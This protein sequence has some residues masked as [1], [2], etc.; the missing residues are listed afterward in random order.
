MSRYKVGIVSGYFDSIHAGHLDYITEA[1]KQCDYLVAIVNSD[2]QM[3]LKGCRK[4][5]GETERLRTVQSIKG[6]SLA[7]LSMDKDESVANTL[8]N[9]AALA[10]TMGHRFAFLPQI[11][12][13]FFNGGDR[14]LGTAN[15]KE[16]DICRLFNI[17]VV[18]LGGDKVDSSTR[19][20][21]IVFQ[22]SS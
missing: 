13:V 12:L 5:F 6:V 17:E 21:E 14:T 7:F 9:V 4:I 2:E 22:E 18:Y 19:I 11:D 1:A 20:R 8:N 15:K 10:A 3:K 16:A